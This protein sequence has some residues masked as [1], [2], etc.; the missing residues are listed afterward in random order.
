MKTRQQS[1]PSPLRNALAQ[2][3]NPSRFAGMSEPMAA[4]VGFILDRHFVETTF[5]EIIVTSDGFLLARAE[6]AVGANHFIGR[7]A[8]LVQNWLALIAAAGLTTHEWIEVAA[9]FAAK[10]GYF[11]RRR[12]RVD[13]HQWLWIWHQ[14]R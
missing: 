13:H 2:K 3:L 4:I 9:L 5:A 8:D 7:H 1:H 11:G 10:I 6:G 14:R 12:G